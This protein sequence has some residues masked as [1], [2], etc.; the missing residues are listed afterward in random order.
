[1]ADLNQKSKQR[2]AFDRLREVDWFTVFLCV[3]LLLTLL[4]P[5]AQRLVRHERVNAVL[6]DAKVAE[7]AARS[8]G[9]S[10]YGR[11]DQFT[12]PTTGTGFTAQAYDEIRQL[13]SVSGDVTLLRVGENGYQILLLEYTDGDYTVRY[14]AGQ[15]QWTVSY[16]Q[17]I[18]TTAPAGQA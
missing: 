14:D 8:V 17:A 9:L 6:A 4:V 11:N 12:D 18:L 5:C 2:R 1:M 15:G 16:L 13:F 10:C 7:L 3:V